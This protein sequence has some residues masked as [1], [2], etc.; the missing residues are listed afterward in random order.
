[1]SQ[2]NTYFCDKVPTKFHLAN[3]KNIK[4]KDKEK[5]ETLGGIGLAS[6]VLRGILIGVQHPLRNF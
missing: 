5:Q 6:G 1:M 2:T 4:E 3:L